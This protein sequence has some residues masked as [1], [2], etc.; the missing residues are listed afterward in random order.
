MR[1][2]RHR[3]LSS[4]QERIGRTIQDTT[5]IAIMLSRGATVTP[6]GQ[7]AIL[8]VPGSQASAEFPLDRVLAIQAE[9]RTCDLLG[10]SGSRPTDRCSD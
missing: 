3:H 8:R 2:H 1:R 7:R 6:I 5:T 9:Q 10:R 4:V